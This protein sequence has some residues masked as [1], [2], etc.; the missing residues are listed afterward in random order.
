MLLLKRQGRA[1]ASGSFQKL[2]IQKGEDCLIGAV[3][4]G[5][6]ADEGSHACPVKVGANLLRQA[7]E[8]KIGSGCFQL[9]R[10]LQNRLGTGDI[11]AGAAPKGEDQMVVFWEGSDSA[12]ELIHGAEEEGTGDVDHPGGFQKG[13]LP[14]S[15]R[16]RLLS[17]SE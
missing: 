13:D 5:G 3:K 6:F 15:S 4:I 14:T 2:P 1:F 17:M 12:V 8:G 11:D 7:A 9:F 10:K 16:R